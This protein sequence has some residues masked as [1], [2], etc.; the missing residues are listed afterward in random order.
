[1]IFT[2][3]YNTSFAC[4]RHIWS[5]PVCQLLKDMGSLT[6]HQL[7]VHFFFIMS[8]CPHFRLTLDNLNIP[9]HLLGRI[10]CFQPLIHVVPT[11]I[12]TMQPYPAFSCSDW[13]KELHICVTC[14]TKKG[15]WNS[16][17][18]GVNRTCLAHN[19]HELLNLISESFSYVFSHNF[20]CSL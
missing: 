8:R 18:F 11:R 7:F 17:C 5:R 1:M 3:G 16:F 2:L 13:L 14:E 10:A 12:K 6:N 9:A 19:S 4:F 20:T 15:N